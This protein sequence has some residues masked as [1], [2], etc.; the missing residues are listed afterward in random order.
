[1]V[2]R[3]REVNKSERMIS[4][5]DHQMHPDKTF[6]NLQ[7]ILRNI[8]QYNRNGLEQSFSSHTRVEIVVHSSFVV[9]S[10]VGVMSSTYIT[11]NYIIIYV[12]LITI[13][14]LYSSI[15]QVTEMCKLDKNSES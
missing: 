13:K 7:N 14:L 10:L 12:M 8:S 11:L 6:S 15:L 9:I 1:M 2:K 4:L 3:L 5:T